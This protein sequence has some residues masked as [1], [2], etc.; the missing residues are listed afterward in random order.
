MAIY[1][2]Q[3]NYIIDVDI[4][5]T[6]AFKAGMV[7][8]RDDNGRAIPADNSTLLY[9]PLQRKAGKHLGFASSDHDV[10]GISIVEPD[11]I[12]ASWLDNNKK[13]QR[14]NHHYKYLVDCKAIKI[15]NKPKINK[16]NN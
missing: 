14:Y 9:L 4:I 12:S 6:T 13:F 8:M 11:V 15:Y 10:S 7:L 16:W 2:V 1:P 5:T 3:S